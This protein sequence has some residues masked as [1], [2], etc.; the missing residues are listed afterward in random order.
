MAPIFTVSSGA[1]ELQQVLR[2]RAGNAAAPVSSLRMII[3]TTLAWEPEWKVGTEIEQRLGTADGDAPKVNCATC[4]NGVY[5]PL[6]GISMAQNF[7]EPTRA[8]ALGRSREDQL[9]AMA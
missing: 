5:K 1:S 8:P 2:Y 6:L 3:A 9:S 7:P 4:H